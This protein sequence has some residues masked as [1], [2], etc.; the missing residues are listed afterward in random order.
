[1]DRRSSYLRAN[2]LPTGN[3]T[4]NFAFLGFQAHI[5]CRETAVLLSLLKQFPAKINR[6][7]IW[8]NSEFFDRNSVQVAANLSEVGARDLAT[9]V[10]R[11]RLHRSTICRLFCRLARNQSHGIFRTFATRSAKSGRQGFD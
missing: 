2:S 5:P 7:M 1:M 10:P 3:L 4:G 8:K 11:L 6:E 9:S